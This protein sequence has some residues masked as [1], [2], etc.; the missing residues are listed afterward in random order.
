MEI[1]IKEGAT[2]RSYSRLLSGAEM[3]EYSKLLEHTLIMSKS[4]ALWNLSIFSLF[5]LG[6]DN[7]SAYSVW[8]GWPASYLYTIPHHSDRRSS[9][10][11]NIE[12]QPL[13]FDYELDIAEN[14][15]FLVEQQ[16]GGIEMDMLFKDKQY[17]NEKKEEKNENFVRKGGDLIKTMHRKRYASLGQDSSPPQ[18]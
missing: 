8:Q 17:D 7:V 16:Q 13:P 9:S 11:I 2:L 4:I 10:V 18:M 1:T 3:D 15:P 5:R 14:K 6:G 12:D